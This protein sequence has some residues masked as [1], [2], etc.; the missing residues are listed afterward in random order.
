M[1]VPERLDGTGATAAALATE[2]LARIDEV[3]APL[4]RAHEAELGALLAE[5]DKW[6]LTMGPVKALE[7]RHKREQR[8]IRTAEYRAGLAALA[9]RYRDAVSGHDS[10]R[11]D[12]DAFVTVGDLVTR[13]CEQLAFNPN[14]D[15][16]LQALM[17]SL[18]ILESAPAH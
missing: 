15:L 6:G 2:A 8:R 5:V 10:S 11:G 16:L 7:D 3:L 17:V 13:S 14:L 18:P 1:G 12:R 4:R 9:G